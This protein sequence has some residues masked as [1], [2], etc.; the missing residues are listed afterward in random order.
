MKIDP[1]LTVALIAQR[2]P[3]AAKVFSKYKIDLCCG[4]VHPLNVVAQKHGLDLHRILKELEAAA[5]EEGSI[6]RS[7]SCP[8]A[9]GGLAAGTTRSSPPSTGE[10]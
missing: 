5:G 6:P 8:E 4:G 9:G 2:H 10:T 7:T 3:E 1:N